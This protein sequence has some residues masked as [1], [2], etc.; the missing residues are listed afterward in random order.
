MKNKM[1][2]SCLLI[3]LLA[4]ASLPAQTTRE[5][6]LKDA[7]RMLAN[8][9]PYEGSNHFTP[10][11][12]GYEPFYVTH[13]ARHGSRHLISNHAYHQLIPLMEK[14]EKKNQLTKLGKIMLKRARTAYAFAKGKS[15]QL[16][17]LGG[18]QHEKTANRLYNNYPL[19]FKEGNRVTAY[20]S[21]VD[22]SR[23]SMEH[24]C[25]E[26]QKLSPGL[27]IVQSCG[28]ECTYFV[29]PGR[30]SIAA[31][32]KSSVRDQAEKMEDSLKAC[33]NI[34]AKIF[35]DP[36]FVTHNKKKH[37][38]IAGYFYEL[39]KSMP[40]MPELGL[41]FNVFDDDQLFTYFKANNINWMERTYVIPGEPPFYKRAYA[42]LRNMISLADEAIRQNV[43]GATL[44]F[45]HDT[46]LFPLA[47]VMG[48][49]GCTGFP[50]QPSEW[51][52][53]YRYFVAG[54]IVPMAANIQIIFFKSRKD[55]D[56]LVKVLLQEK[57][58]HIPV[59]TDMW[60]YYHWD[61]VRAYYLDLMNN[62]SPIEYVKPHKAAK[63]DENE[64]NT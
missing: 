34:S 38:S 3:L 16:T 58:K 53:S 13:Y 45:G 8:Y 62:V 22:R 46:F 7:N 54:D 35:K 42:T 28:D 27:Q 19:M 48:V 29:R 49:D 41:D 18:Q 6:V 51:E 37:S 40:H 31:P 23:L 57:E 15:G 64:I 30:D 9:C 50:A 60:P 47:Y 63:K 25:A 36:G 11:P 56:I 26:L 4:V 2:V 17:R 12:E 59:K 33:V 14:A 24:F 21:P 44:R 61:D 55:N 5:E 10:V 52:D 20:S 39:Y 43:G 1:R 32:A